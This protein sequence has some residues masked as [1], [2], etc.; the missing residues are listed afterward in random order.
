MDETENTINDKWGIHEYNNWIKEGRPINAI[1][2]DLYIVDNS[3]ITSLFGIEKL[4]NLTRLWYCNNQIP[5]FDGIEK[6]TK[7]THLYCNDNQIPSLD[8]I[9]K[10][11][12]LTHLC[13]N[14]NKL[15]S[16]D[17][18]ENL[19]NLTTLGCNGNKLTS[20]DGI[21]QL[22]K[23]ETLTCYNNQITSLNGIENLTNL[24]SFACN[25]NQITSLDGIEHLTNLRSLSCE[26]NQITSL[27]GVEHLTNLT[28]LDC[29]SNQITSL[30]GIENLRQLRHL[31]CANNPIEHIPPNINRIL[32]RIRNGQNVYGDGQ[33]VHNH[34]IQ[35]SIRTSVKKILEIKPVICDTTTI[36]NYILQ[37][38]IFTDETKRILVEYQSSTDIYSVLE[39]TFGE[40]L[41]YVI[42]RIEVN[43][44]KDEIKRIL[45]TEMSESVC[46]CFT[47]RI[48]RLVNCLAGFDPLVSIQIA[49]NE[50]IANIISTVARTLT[51]DGTYSVETH[52]ELVKKQMEELG[53]SYTIIDEW[54][55]YIE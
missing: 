13:C 55:N 51:N 1:V 18:I 7:L 20:L 39:I 14:G 15:T 47:G 32:N 2:T 12:K 25:H 10:L 38:T 19:T 6:L 28:T 22:T 21:Q 8:G 37:D 5:S 49:D 9:E 52:K 48:S 33:N 16:L 45:N 34:S 31:G 41:M 35:E 27:D 40:L 43:K 44:D 17:G 23:L 3:N 53:Y 29:R 50:Q 36:T 26:Y 24:R 11:T 46:K 4:T 42:N 54:V 30:N